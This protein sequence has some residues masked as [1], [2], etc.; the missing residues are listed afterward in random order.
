MKTFALRFVF[1]GL[2]CLVAI[3]GCS[4]NEW[5]PTRPWNLIRY[6]FV[7]AWGDSGSG[8]GQFFYPQGV[9]VDAGGNVYVMD[10]ANRRIQKF[11]GSGV[12]LTQWGSSGTGDGQFG[13][14]N[15]IA[16]DASG[17]VYVAY[18]EN[19]RIQKFTS[20]GVYMTQWITGSNISE[21]PYNPDWQGLAVDAAGNVYVV[22]AVL[23]RI[24][25]FT[26]D[27]APITQWDTEQELFRPWSIAVDDRGNV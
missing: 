27:G 13:Y 15:D 4:K 16:V 10:T 5:V 25:K 6:D 23:G 17:N 1:V 11:T 26:A 7:Q 12:Y 14:A 21:W 3:A 18:A 9:A 2:P 22:H 8:N 20:D 19:G 24:Q